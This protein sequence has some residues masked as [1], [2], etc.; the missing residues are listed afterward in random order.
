MDGPIQGGCHCPRTVPCRFGQTDVSVR[1]GW[2][3]RYYP[4]NVPC[5]FG[6]KDG[7]VQSGWNYPCTMPC[8]I[9]RDGRSDSVWCD[10]RHDG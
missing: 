3:G 5:G 1:G 9:W 4:L 2:H 6:P 10:I 7:L 8:E